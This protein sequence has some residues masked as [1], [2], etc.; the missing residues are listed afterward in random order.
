MGLSGSGMLMFAASPANAQNITWTGT[1]SGDWQN[2]QNW[3]SASLPGST[4]YLFINS[5]TPNAAVVDNSNAQAGVIFLGAIGGPSLTVQN[6][7]VLTSDTA[8]ISN[9]TNG[10]TPGTSE[11][12]SGTAT[13]NGVGSQ[14][15]ANAFNVGFYGT[16]TMNV[17][18][19]GKAIA[20]TTV[21]LGSHVGSFGA[22]K[23][24]G[25]GSA[26]Q[27]G[28]F[29]VS[30]NGASVVTISDRGTAQ[31]SGLLVA[32]SAGS[33]GTVETLV[34][35]HLKPTIADALEHAEKAEAQRQPIDTEVDARTRTMS[36]I[37][38]RRGQGPFR[39]RLLDA[40]GRRCAITACAAVE[41][42]EAAHIVPYAGEPTNRVDNGLLLRSDIHTLFDLGLLWVDVD[43]M[44]VRV[45]RALRADY[46]QYHGQ[47]LTL[48]ARTT[49]R[50]HLEHLRSHGKTACEC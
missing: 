40:Y 35:I 18:G 22:L 45:A 15:T 21:S 43:T 46:G 48:P 42:L 12:Q 26:V 47:A 34:P 8:I 30:D 5:V 14:W 3:S 17:T 49:D 13:I 1:Q 11:L 44:T 20:A 32:N 25:A 10:L 33:T 38:Q 50:P 27:S 19:G 36:A 28:Q 6:G 2:A 37:V 29:T 31:V 23:I 24:T 41:A 39:E 7:G 16:G 4:G 9:S